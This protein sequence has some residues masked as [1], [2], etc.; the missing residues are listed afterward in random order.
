MTTPHAPL[1]AARRLLPLAAA[2]ALSLVA[3]TAPAATVTNAD[4]TWPTDPIV[5]IAATPGSNTSSL[6]T[7]GGSSGNA[8][9]TAEGPLNAIN[10]QLGDKYLNFQQSGSG[11]ITTLGT[12]GPAGIVYALR[13]GTAIDAPERDPVSVVLE[14]T[15]SPN[16]AITLNSIWTQIYSGPSG[17]AIDPGRL[18]IGS[19]IDFTN[20]TV[21]S[22]YRLLVSNVRTPGSANSMAFGEVELIGDTVVPEPGTAVLVGLGFLAAGV[23]VRRRPR[24]EGQPVVR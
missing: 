11:F 22:S 19:R 10:N 6:A 15:N 7:S 4:L 1:V 8:Y 5:A 24:R 12:N 21:Y 20:T 18:N 14:G 9:P 2:C 23:F 17:L 16:P 3:P 13:F